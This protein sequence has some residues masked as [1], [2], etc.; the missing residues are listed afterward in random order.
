MAHTIGTKG[1]VVIEKAIREKLG[2]RA[3]YR[4]I[5][6]VS[7][8]HVEIFFA[9]PEH[10]RSLRGAAK[11]LATKTPQPY[12][13]DDTRIAATVA[14]DY[15]TENNLKKSSAHHSKAMRKR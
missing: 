15:A 10:A 7:G 4:A 1:Q 13:A 9:P 14:A 11:S 8:D 3:G 12:E 6:F 2:V 5:Q